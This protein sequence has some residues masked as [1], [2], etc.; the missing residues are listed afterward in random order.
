MTQASTFPDPRSLS[1]AALLLAAC[2]L[3]WAAPQGGPSA[4]EGAAALRVERLEIVDNKG[5]EKPMVAATIMVPAGWQRSGEVA[6]NPAQ[7]CGKPYAP[8]FRAVAPDG[9]SKIELSAQETWGATNYGAPVGE[10]PQ[11]HLA[12]AREYLES[13]VQRNRANARLLDYK[14]RPDRS[15]VL[16]DHQS[17]GAQLRAWVDSGQALIGYRVDGREVFELLATNVSYTHTRLAG[18]MGGQVMESLQGQALGVLSW[19][20]SPAPVAQRHFDLVWDTLK[21]APEWSA[22]IA[23]AE[24]QIAA[25]NAATQAQ[26]G[27]IQAETSRET[28]QHI[29]KRGQIRHQTQQE[30]AQ[31]QNE[32][33]RSSQATQERMRVDNVRSIREVHGY[34]DAHSGGV[35]ELSNHYD[36]AWQLRDGSYVLTDDP[37]FDPARAFG[38]QGERLQ[39][40]R[41]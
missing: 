16:G 32:G 10:C 30:I 1:V 33:W 12:G 3:A 11:A 34:R 17:A 9:I 37:N 13:W 26:I 41:E 21:P 38:V 18:G 28:L 31:M 24:S 7:R 6:W 40:T 27:R 29:A 23:A 25:D 20:T 39:R 36:H 4:K 22:R 14:P 8:M 5:F 19:R 2:S 15:R 35:V